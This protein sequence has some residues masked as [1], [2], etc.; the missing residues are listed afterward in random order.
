M[1]DENTDNEV[2]DEKSVIS[3]E[4]DSEKDDFQKEIKFIPSNMVMV[5]KFKNEINLKA[6][7][8]LL[9]IVPFDYKINSKANNREKI[10]YFGVERAIVSIKFNKI[11]RGIITSNESMSNILALNLQYCNKN[12][13][14]KLSK[15]NFVLLGLLDDEMGK[16]ASQIVMKHIIMVEKLFQIENKEENIEWVLKILKKNE[17]DIYMY[18]DDEVE[19]ALENI[20]EGLNYDFCKFLTMFT[21]DYN[22]YELIKNKFYFMYSSNFYCYKKIPRIIS[23]EIVNCVYNYNL[24]TNLSLVSL[25]LFLNKSGYL[26]SYNNWD[27]PNYMYIMIPLS[28]IRDINNKGD[29]DISQIKMKGKGRIKAHRFRI[30]RSGAIRQTSP[31]AVSEALK[32]RDMIINEIYNFFENREIN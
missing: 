14:M 2:S 26:V 11:N 20:P 15:S 18:I 22:N 19:N 4:T 10:P 23:N 8:E 21:F 29:G 30:N 25:S 12:I 31:V 9:T 13:H 5:T 3:T 32:V 6:V 17:T 1:L 28:I 7:S 16:M 27:E 24:N